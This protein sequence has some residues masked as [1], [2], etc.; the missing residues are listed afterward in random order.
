MTAFFAMKILEYCDGEGHGC[1]KTNI[2][3]ARSAGMRDEMLHYR[4]ASLV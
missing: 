2:N 4:R 1:L 3:L